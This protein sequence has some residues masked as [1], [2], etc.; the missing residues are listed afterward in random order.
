MYRAK[1]PFITRSHKAEWNI[2]RQVKHVNIIITTE[3]EEEETLRHGD[4]RE[5][6]VARPRTMD[7]NKERF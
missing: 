4:M 1:Q 5:T 2:F 7:R 3:E 6:I